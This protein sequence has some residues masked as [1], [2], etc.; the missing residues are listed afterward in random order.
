MYDANIHLVVAHFCQ[1]HPYKN[2]VTEWRIVGGARW[3]HSRERSEDII[4]TVIW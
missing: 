3:K 2:Q 1:S 4:N